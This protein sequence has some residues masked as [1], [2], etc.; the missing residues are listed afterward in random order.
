MDD[1]HQ[2]HVDHRSDIDLGLPSDIDIGDPSAVFGH[3]AE[4]KVPLV[5]TSPK[6]TKIEVQ[7]VN[8]V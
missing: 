3:R 4:K 5:Y 7:P 6:G 8:L 2:Q 1:Q